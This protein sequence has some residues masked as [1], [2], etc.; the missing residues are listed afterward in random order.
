LGSPSTNVSKFWWGRKNLT[1]SKTF[2]PQQ[3]S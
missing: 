2:T 1:S 3:P